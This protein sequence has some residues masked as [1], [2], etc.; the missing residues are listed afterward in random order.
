MP[1]LQYHGTKEERAVMRKKYLKKKN[2]KRNMVEFPVTVTTYEIVCRDRKDI[3]G[4]QWKYL[5]VD[6]GHRLKNHKCRL[7][8]ELN[9]LANGSVLVGGANKILLTGTP[10]QNNLTE[11]WSLLNFLMPEIFDDLEFFQSVFAFDGVGEDEAEENMIEREA[12]GNIVSKLH[13]ILAPFMMRRLK[14]DVEESL[15]D[16]KEVVMYVPMK[17]EQKEMYDSIVSGELSKILEAATGNKTQLNNV[18][19][20]LRKCSLHPYLH[21]EPN[22]ASGNLSTDQRII[23]VSGKLSVLDK[24]LSHFQKNGHKTLV[25]SQFTS[26]LDII[27]DYLVELR[28]Q[29]KHCRIDGTVSL[30]SRKSQMHSFNTDPD[31]LCF[32]LST[33]AGGVGINLTAADTVIIFDSDWN[34]HQDNQA[35]DRC[36]RIG[37]T[38]DV[39]VYRLITS[40]SVELKILDKANSKRKLE[41]VVCAKQATIHNKTRKALTTADLRDLLRN[42]FTG[43]LAN[44]GAIDD[45]SITTLLDRS[46]VLSQDFPLKDKGYE[47]VDH[48]ASSIVGGINT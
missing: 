34:P 9:E 17:K 48:K 20:Q 28:P 37:Q 24:M 3:Q 46:K 36:H 41:R 43:H 32:L 4:C 31:L 1:V 38:K 44:C 6:E 29:Y 42:D 10:L 47:I 8:R 7:F 45:E 23:D 35:Q 39:M 22:D 13:K 18:M 25:F 5:I 11:L 14:R 30:D 27:E 21:F 16:K 19:M 2:Q 15:P 26:M 40:N 33:R 12:S